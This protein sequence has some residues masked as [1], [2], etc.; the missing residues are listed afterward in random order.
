MAANRC[1][2]WSMNWRTW[3]NWL[4]V[5]IQRAAS[6]GRTSSRT[7]RTQ[8]PRVQAS[9]ASRTQ[10]RVRAGRPA[11]QKCAPASS[12]ARA[13]GKGQRRALAVMDIS[14]SSLTE[15]PARRAEATR[16][17]QC[18]NPCRNG[19]AGG[20]GQRPWRSPSSGPAVRQ[21]GF[22]RARGSS[23]P[24]ADSACRSGTGCRYG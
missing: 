17:A 8:A 1:Q 14:D 5:Q 6:R 12:S 9:R 10:P 4:V 7:R 18:R 3:T 16:K 2:G 11:R 22:K 13:A 20:S 21:D 15:I 23:L 24:P 19:S